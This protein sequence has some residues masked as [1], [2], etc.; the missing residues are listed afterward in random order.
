MINSRAELLM[1]AETLLS[2]KRL[3][4]ATPDTLMHPAP[5]AEFLVEGTVLD[6]R[7]ICP[8]GTRFQLSKEVL[9]WS[10]QFYNPQTNSYVW[11]APKGSVIDG[12]SIPRI[13][14]SLV[15]SPFSGS[16]KRSAA[17][18]DVECVQR[19][20]PS[21]LIHHLFKEMLDADG[22]TGWRKS[23]MATAVILGGPSW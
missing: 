6:G 4:N 19:D 22:V 9:F 11:I 16:Y 7:F 8:K 5:V 3:T 13:M 1:E 12:A 2:V 18:H 10:R 15:G 20:H 14:W 17:I 23:A 21:E